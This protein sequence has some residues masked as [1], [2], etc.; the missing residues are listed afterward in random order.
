MASCPS[1]SHR[2]PPTAR[3][4]AAAR[5][6]LPKPRTTL[7]DVGPR[8]AGSSLVGSA[9]ERPQ[10]EAALTFTLRLPPGAITPG[11]F[12]ERYTTAIRQ[13]LRVNPAAADAVKSLHLKSSKNALT[14]SLL[15]PEMHALFAGCE[16]GCARARPNWGGDEG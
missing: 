2:P 13:A 1:H 9:F 5:A 3:V 4:Q 12:R 8:P 16:D 7:A 15:V 11:A 14:C 10:V 6:V